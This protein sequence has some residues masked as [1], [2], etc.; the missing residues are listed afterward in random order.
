MI[1]LYR[2]KQLRL[3]RL[4]HAIEKPNLSKRLLIP[5]I[6]AHNAAMKPVTY[7]TILLT[8]VLSVSC[9][10]QPTPQSANTQT[11]QPTARQMQMWNRSCALCHIDGNAGAPRI[12]H[13][14]E[15]Q[16]VLDQAP[17]DVLSRVI[18][19]YNDMPPLGY[20][21]ACEEADFQALIDMMLISADKP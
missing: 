2:H 19:G 16:S 11:G 4:T 6:Y 10:E 18:S 5:A 21:M 8:L 12:G 9:S 1:K 14:D 17:A 3:S 15:W 13:A 20:C 7:S